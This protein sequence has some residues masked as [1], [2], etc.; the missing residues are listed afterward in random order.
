M[1]K[2]FYRGLKLGVVG[3]GQLGRMLI[4]ASID[5]NVEIHVLDPDPEAPCKPY[6]HAFTQGSLDDYETVYQFGKDLDVITVEIEKVNADALATLKA[7]GKTVYPDPDILRMIQDKRAQKAYY[8]EHGLP[9]ADFVLV[10]NAS[11]VREL[12]W[13][14]AVNKLGKDGY[15]GRG[16]QI[17]REPA[18]FD[19]AFDAPGLVEKMVE[20]EKE[21]A[22]I[23]A[24]NPQGDIKTYPLVE[25]VFHPEHNLVEYLY[26]PADVPVVQA[27]RAREIAV[28]LVKSLDYVGLLAI[29]M[30]AL[31]NGEVLINE[32]APRPHN[33]G[34]HTIRACGTSQYEQHLRAIL[35][36]PLGDTTLLTPAAMVNLLGAEG[37]TGPAV[38]VGMEDALAIPGVFPHLYG[39]AETRPF[40]KMGHVTIIDRDVDQLRDKVM[41]V[42]DILKVESDRGAGN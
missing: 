8:Q 30:F 40:R 2:Y 10:N 24:R 38:Y 22:I 11:E 1:A 42:K 16:V 7:E 13:M 29:E 26:S 25:M 4:Q 41:R 36:L 3:G 18:D 15:D 9:T 28:D 17:L 14:P 12:G 27:L 32:I 39:K 5:F 34:H 19:K 35:G 20:F 37:H 21:I 23:V 31:K 33:S 6:A